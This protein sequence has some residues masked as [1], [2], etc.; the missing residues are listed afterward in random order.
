[1]VHEHMSNGRARDERGAVAVVVALLVVCFAILAALVVDLGIA[2]D[3]RRVSQNA[4]D[5]A[6]LAGSNRLFPESKTC[7]SGTMPCYADAVATVK[8]YAD[9]NFDVA[10]GDWASCSNPGKLTYVVPGESSCISF[11]SATSPSLILV[12][13][14]TRNVSTA[15]GGVVGKASIPVGSEAQAV[16]AKDFNCT[17]CFLDSVD[18]GNAD[19]TVIGGSIAV[20]GDLTAGANSYWNATANY[21]RGTVNVPGSHDNFNPDVSAIA[22]FTDPLANLTP[23][24]PWNVSALPTFTTTKPCTTGPGIYTSDVIF[25]TNCTLPAGLY[26][27]K[28]KWTV[29]K[30]SNCEIDAPNVTLYVPSPGQVDFKNGTIR[31]SAPTTGVYANLALIYD[32]DNT[33][34]IGLQ[35]N[36][37]STVS[38]TVYAFNGKFEFNGTSDFTFNGGPIV[39]RGV[40]KGVG[41][42]TLLIENA[43]EIRFARS[44]LGLNK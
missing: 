24:L 44:V 6:A 9:L 37:D 26:V 40:V 23:T 12:R 20:N 13:M 32:R 27:V 14:P 2:R 19:F 4:S 25:D 15:F 16:I 1:M 29:K 31:L 34:P 11:N 33:N 7:S 42:S 35:G 18:T 43:K 17:L 5:A 38:G 41:D 10:P 8:Q 21:V 36:G 3:T 28:G 39:V 22:P 30:N